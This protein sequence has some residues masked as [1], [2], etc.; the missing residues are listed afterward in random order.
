MIPNY[1]VKIESGD[2]V[3]RVIDE[4]TQ[5]AQNGDYVFRGYNKQSELLPSIVR[6]K[7]S[8]KDVEGELLKNFEKYGSHYFHANTPID[9]MSYAQHFG[10]PTRLLDFTCNPFIAL[11]FALY[12]PKSKGNY[13]EPEDKEYYYIRYASRSENLCESSILLNDDIYNT[14]FTRTDSLAI[15]ASQ[16]ID[17]VTDLFGKN[18]LQRSVYSLNGVNGTLDDMNIETTKNKRSSYSLYRSKPI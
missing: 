12:T 18:N 8:Y 9:F 5:L 10:V 4:L 1:V 16:S 13:N 14:E 6:E 7:I 2:G 3:Q 17:N 15:R 11:S